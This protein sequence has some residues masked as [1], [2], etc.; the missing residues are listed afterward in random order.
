MAPRKDLQNPSV[1]NWLS[2]QKSDARSPLRS[3]GTP[4]CISYQTWSM[5]LPDAVCPKSLP[6]WFGP[7]LEG[8]IHVLNSRDKGTRL[9]QSGLGLVGLSREQLTTAAG[10]LWDVPTPQPAAPHPAL[11]ERGAQCLSAHPDPR[12]TEQCG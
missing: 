9:E 4:S 7:V 10:V 8:A 6:Y 11:L 2:L 5:P 1:Q 3:P 12:R